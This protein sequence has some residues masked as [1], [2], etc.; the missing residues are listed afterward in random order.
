MN[1]T[2]GS[3]IASARKPLR[4]SLLAARRWVIVAMLL[5]LHAA[6]IAL[7]GGPSATDYAS[8]YARDFAR[9]WLL[10]HF[11]LFLLWQPFVS[12]DRDL[13]IAAVLL[14]LGITAA[15]LYALDGWMLVTW[16]AILI[17]IMGGKVFMLRA[18]RRSRFYLVA[19]FYLLAILL[20]WVVPVQL[21]DIR[22]LP[23]GVNVV[24][25]F[26]LPFALLAMVFLPYRSEDETEAHVFDFFYSL[27]VFQLVVVLVLGSLAAMRATHNEYFSAV[28]LTVFGFAAALFVLAML[29]GPRAGFGGLRTYFSRYLLS[30]GMP[31][32]LWMRRIAELFETKANAAEFLHAA[33]AEVA[34]VPWLLGAS[35]QSPDEQG[36]FGEETSHGAPFR[37]HQ[38][39]VTLFSETRLSPALLLHL[40]LLAQVVGEFYES[41]RREQSQKQTTYLQAVHETGA[42]LTHDIKNLLQSIYALTSAGAAQMDRRQAGLEARSTTPYEMLLSRQLPELSKRLQTTLDKLQNPEIDT[43]DVLI[44]ARDW[45]Q[46][47]LARHSGRDAQFVRA[48]ELNELIPSALFDTVLENCLQN[49]RKK[50]ER[51]PGIEIVVTLQVDEGNTLSI[52]DNGSAI[53]Q[54][55]AAQLFRAP[56]LRGPRGA[57]DA[58][59]RNDDGLGIGLY[60]A[61]RQA[62]RAG[63]GLVLAVNLNGGVT[64]A[65]RLNRASA[66]A[67][68]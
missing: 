33:M 17:G 63:W 51:E 22:D 41:K 56:I 15:A 16:I 43:A 68:L 20:T 36:Q 42:S 7:S 1:V 39:N 53:P 67:L 58:S 54:D 47:V 29:W 19:L 61:A 13:N 57:G 48:G 8:H 55:I 6:I 49:A 66:S 60:Q 45:W 27:F 37:F 65:L 23:A 34:T 44:P 26:V 30:V 62:E 50:R 32:E 38:L 59:V 25:T 5:S 12:T 11:G 4:Q 3:P 40:R 18:A 64:F 35:W 28:L 52:S 14:L 21:L 31:F 9:I 24:A 46:A 2:P 10:V